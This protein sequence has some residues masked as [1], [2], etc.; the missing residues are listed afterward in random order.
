[1]FSLFVCG[2]ATQTSQKNAKIRL[3]LI[4]RPLYL[5]VLL[6]KDQKEKCHPA[7]SI[8]NY[9]GKEDKKLPQLF[10]ELPNMIPSKVGKNMKS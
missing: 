10:P 7:F 1:M 5:P 8:L 3:I 9:C 6:G 4:I 2:P